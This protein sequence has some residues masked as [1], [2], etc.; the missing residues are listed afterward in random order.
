MRVLILTTWAVYGQ[1]AATYLL[2]KN[3]HSHVI[4]IFSLPILETTP[5]TRDFSVIHGYDVI[6]IDATRKSEPL[7][8]NFATEIEKFSDSGRGVV[9]ANYTQ[10]DSPETALSGNFQRFYHPLSYVHKYDTSSEPHLGKV[11]DPAHPIMQNVSKFFSHSL[12]H[13]THSQPASNMVHVVANWSNGFPLIAE[14]VNP[15]GNAIVVALNMTVAS[16]SAFSG[17]WNKETCDGAWIVHNSILYA[18]NWGKKRDWRRQMMRFTTNKT[19]TNV[20]I[21]FLT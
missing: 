20:H 9:V 8:T 4:P 6:L 5:N 11:A 14:R 2:A 12:S 7:P 17:F 3:L 15:R 10:L 13:H 16:H 18:A 19:L 21:V 1:D